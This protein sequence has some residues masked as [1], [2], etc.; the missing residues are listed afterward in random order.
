MKN[1]N[2][3][4]HPAALGIVLGILLSIALCGAALALLLSCDLLYRIDIRALNIPDYSGYDSETVLRNYRAAVAYLNPFATVGVFALPDLGVSEYGA[5]HFADVRRLTNILF[6]AAA[7]SLPLVAAGFLFLHGNALRHRAYIACGA[8]VL[9]LP[10]LLCGAFAIDAD[11]AFVLFHRIFFTNDY[12]LFSWDID[13]VIRILPMEFFIHCA[14]VIAFFL[15]V[16][17]VS[18]LVIGIR[19][20]VKRRD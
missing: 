13:Q 14:L 2:E 3:A 5:I 19:W 11:G 9:A 7:V 12:W 4:K 10:T 18:T 16:G 6:A 20:A 8:T 17:G 15:A 1:K